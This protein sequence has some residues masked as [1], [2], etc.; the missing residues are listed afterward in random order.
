VHRNSDNKTEDSITFTDVPRP[1]GGGGEPPPTSDVPEPTT[2]VLFGLG[3]P[4]LGLARK[5]RRRAA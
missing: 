2:I 4:A 5:F 3:L 1:T